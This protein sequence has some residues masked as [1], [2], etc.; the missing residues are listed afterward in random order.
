MCRLKRATFIVRRPQNP[1]SWMLGVIGVWIT[2]DLGG[3]AHNT[4]IPN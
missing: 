2:R 4:A 3:Q 1:G